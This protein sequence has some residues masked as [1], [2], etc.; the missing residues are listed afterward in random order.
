MSVPSSQSIK[1]S[2]T[3]ERV[4]KTKY[5]VEYSDE[6]S[7]ETDL[8]EDE[9]MEKKLKE[10]QE[11]EL[12]EFDRYFISWLK[13]VNACIFMTTYKSNNVFAVGQTPTD[14]GDK[15]AMYFTN[16]V[17][18]MGIKAY[19]NALWLATGGNIWKFTRVKNE[20]IYDVTFMPRLIYTTNDVD[21]HDIAVNSKG[22]PHF[23]STLFSCIATPS[24]EKSF[25]KVWMPNWISKLAAEDRCHLNGLCMVDGELKYVSSAST[26]DSRTAWK[27]ENRIGNGVIVDVQANNGQGEIVCNGL[28]M[29]HSPRWYKGKLWL[30]EAGT[31]YFGYVDFE[32]KSFVKKAF[33]PAY[34]RGLSFI[35][36]YAVIGCSD[37]R[38][39][40]AFRG[41]PLHD[42]IKSKNTK[43]ICGLVVVDLDTMDI[44]H[45]MKFLKLKELYDVDILEGFTCPRVL[46]LN[47]EATMR[48]YKL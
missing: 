35:K 42:N 32:K 47:Q 37:D 36:D 16:F 13:S 9:L 43:P 30:L 6:P 11:N 39:E 1:S 20:G 31:G 25:N 46:D 5:D 2:G 15:I 41:L 28:T 8:D 24:T 14:E 44:I 10:A 17:R 19:D 26:F 38:H 27:E 23:V 22:K 40:K 12:F 3:A 48:M 21:A 34:I 7:N 29:P 33:I 45:E 4:E 18:P